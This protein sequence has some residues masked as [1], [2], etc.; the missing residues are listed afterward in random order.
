MRVLYQKLD[1]QICV[2]IALTKYCNVAIPIDEHC[3]S[4]KRGLV[5]FTSTTDDT[6][7]LFIETTERTAEYVMDKLL[8][9]GYYNLNDLRTDVISDFY[10][11]GDNNS[12]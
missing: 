10:I 1:N 6:K 4:T 3:T 8:K 5:M 7:K 11:L 2:E 12:L 9:M